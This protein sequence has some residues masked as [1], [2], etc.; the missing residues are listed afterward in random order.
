MPGNR[1]GR[2]SEIY[3]YGAGCGNETN[4]GLIRQALANVFQ[5]AHISIDSDLLGAARGLFQH[6]PGIVGILGTGSN[7]GFYDG[8]KIIDK[9]PSLGYILGDEGSGNHLGRMLLRGFFYGTLPEDLK[10]M[11]IEKY[12]DDKERILLSIY[13]S[14]YPNATMST[15]TTFIMENLNHE[16]IREMVGSA[17][18]EL[19]RLFNHFY[20]GAY[21]GIKIKFTGSVAW[22]ARKVLIST[23]EKFDIEVNEVVQS[24]MKGLIEFHT[25][26]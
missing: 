8:N 5:A 17:F 3:F 7:S 15:Y 23:A 4:S 24:P 6:D 22:L 14:E 9:I 12:G 21:T 11:F 10:S 25:N 20:S 1:T 16:F 13:G 2:I 18:G 26:I 19:F